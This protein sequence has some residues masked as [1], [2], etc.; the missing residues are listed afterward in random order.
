MHLDLC[1]SSARHNHHQP[2]RCFLA[3]DFGLLEEVGSS[4]RCPTRRSTP[5]HTRTGLLYFSPPRNKT[6]L[7]PITDSSVLKHAD[8]RLVR[9]RSDRGT[10]VQ[11]QADAAVNPDTAAKR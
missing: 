7:V 1:L 10:M 2:G 4:G 3:L 6:V 8:V 5:V 11:C 9:R